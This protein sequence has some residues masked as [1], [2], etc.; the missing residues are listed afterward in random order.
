RAHDPWRTSPL[1]A[2]LQRALAQWYD[3]AMDRLSPTASAM[4]RA[5]S[6]R[7]SSAI[8]AS[9]AL[10][11]GALSSLG[12]NQSE[13]AGGAAPSA[14]ASAAPLSAEQAWLADDSQALTPEIYEALVINL[15]K[16]E[17]NERGIE[18][19]CEAYRDLKKAR[20]RN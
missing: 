4:R 11:L 5:R 15:A 16:C 14:S 13:S 18:P 1:G 20:S 9:A 10:L 6:Q 12:C 8:T 2:G 19:R 7:S 17:L 3:H